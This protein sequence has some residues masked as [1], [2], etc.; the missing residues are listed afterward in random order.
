MRKVEHI[1]LF[2]WS[3][4]MGTEMRR[5]RDQRILVVYYSMTGNTARVARDI[6]ARTGADLESIRDTTHG[7]GFFGFLK[8]C[9]G[10]LCGS[11]PEIGPLTRDINGYDLTIIGTP[12]WAGR[13]TP[14]IRA[15]LQIARGRLGRVAFFITSGN[16]EVASLL[17]EL[18]TASGT[19]AAASAGFNQQELKDPVDYGERLTAFLTALR[20]TRTGRQDHGDNGAKA[21]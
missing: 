10:A 15:Y 11:V 16:T 2:P 7:T 21:A 8:A 9:F 12:V 1:L 17:P 6:A 18:E 19:T 5:D 20:L 13:M 14:A 4:T 3:R